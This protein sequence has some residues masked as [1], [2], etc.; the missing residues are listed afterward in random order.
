[1]GL[2]IGCNLGVKMFDIKQI[3]SFYPEYLIENISKAVAEVKLK[4]ETAVKHLE[5]L[6]QIYKK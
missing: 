6:E 3:E 4:K 5:L 1:M 2:S